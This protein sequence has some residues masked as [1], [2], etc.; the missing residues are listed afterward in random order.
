LIIL[1]FLYQIPDEDC[2][3]SYS[4]FSLVAGVADQLKDRQNKGQ[5]QDNGQE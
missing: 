4:W 2:A 3:G 1:I 5:N